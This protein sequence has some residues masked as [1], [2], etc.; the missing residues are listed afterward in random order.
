MQC[1]L[2][3]IPP[4]CKVLQLAPFFPSPFP[5]LPA[6]VIPFWGM[7][8]ENTL[9]ETR[10]SGTGYAT[11]RSHFSEIPCGRLHLAAC[12][13]HGLWP[14]ISPLGRET[15]EKELIIVCF[16]LP[17]KNLLLPR[18]SSGPCV[19]LWNIC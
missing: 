16:L 6:H 10:G 13:P 17:T 18:V 5:R 11:L 7:L 14:V 1:L 9:G 8:D 19:S 3:L 12:P 15:G 4:T 2:F